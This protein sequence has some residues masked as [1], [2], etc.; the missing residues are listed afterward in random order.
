ML[1]ILLKAC[2]RANLLILHKRHR[3][4]N[5]IHISQA[6]THM[7]IRPILILLLSCR[8]TTKP[9]TI[10]DDL[11]ATNKRIIK[12]VTKQVVQYSPNAILIIASNPLDAMCHVAMEESWFPTQSDRHGRVLDSARFRAFIA[13]ELMFPLKTYTLWFWADMAKPWCHYRAFP[14]S[15]AYELQ[16]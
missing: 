2:L 11:L 13:M 16:N 3:L 4:K 10:W 9:G 14:Q 8:N 15:L 6:L 7:K 1:I 5:T 12:N